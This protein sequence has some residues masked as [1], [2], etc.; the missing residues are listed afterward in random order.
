MNARTLEIP[1]PRALPVS[2]LGRM[3][4]F[5][6]VGGTVGAVVA[7]N[8]PMFNALP[9]LVGIVAGLALSSPHRG[10]RLDAL[11]SRSVFSLGLASLAGVAFVGSSLEVAWALA[12]AAG[13]SAI[14]ASPSARGKRLVVGVLG[15][16]LFV[17]LGFA[18][19]TFVGTS[20]VAQWATD[21]V[22]VTAIASAI[23]GAGGY[24]AASST[25][26]PLEVDADRPRLQ[27]A[28]AATESAGDFQAQWQDLTRTASGVEDLL[29]R[30]SECRPDDAVLIDEVRDGVTATVRAAQR[31]LARWELVDREAESARVRRLEERVADNRIALESEGDAA[32]VRSIEAT[33][34]RQERALEALKAVD[35]L[36]R[37]FAFRLEE[38]EASLEVLRLQVEH[39]LTAGDELD[40]AEVDALVDALADAHALFEEAES[41]P[42]AA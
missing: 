20:L 28:Q 13:V 32:V 17:G 37:T 27:E 36:R 23:V 15:A 39:A 25:A 21:D 33:L 41:A 31:G 1:I 10:K 29:D 3:A 30:L 22:W 2:D 18:L 42:V 16:A 12:I 9:T 24:L 19:A 40:H 38:A 26:A 7:M 5:S 35:A 11:L 34:T 6:A 8:T 14:G 4:A